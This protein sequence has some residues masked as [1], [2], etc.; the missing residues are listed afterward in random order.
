[1]EGKVLVLFVVGVFVS[2]PGTSCSLIVDVSNQSSSLVFQILSMEDSLD[3][4]STLCKLCFPM[5]DTLSVAPINSLNGTCQFPK[6]RVSVSE[7]SHKELVEDGYSCSP[8]TVSHILAIFFCLWP[9]IDVS[10]SLFYI[11]F[12]V[13]VVILLALLATL[14]VRRYSVQRTTHVAD[15][16][17]REAESIVT[18]LPGVS[19][20]EQSTI[21]ECTDQTESANGECDSDVNTE[22][23][24]Q[25]REENHLFPYTPCQSEAS[26]NG[27]IAGSKDSS[28]FRLPLTPFSSRNWGPESPFSIPATLSPWIKLQKSNSH[29]SKSRRGGI[30]KQTNVDSFASSNGPGGGV[31]AQTRQDAHSCV[32]TV[33]VVTH[34]VGDTD[35]LFFSTITGN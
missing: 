5:H 16:H 34:P 26:F 28:L 35:Y 21:M 23:E 25:G 24:R 1:M 14:A 15:T 12:V 22:C 13:A 2:V 11:L 20:S 10:C 19:D 18:R 7:N 8:W 6:E 9:S 17:E 3:F 30:D 33:I 4:L 27:V 32:S 31:T 29:T